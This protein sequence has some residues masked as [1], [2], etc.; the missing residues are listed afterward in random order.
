M[1]GSSSFHS[2]NSSGGKSR[3]TSAPPEIS[4]N[5]FDRWMPM[6]TRPTVTMPRYSPRSR[7]AEGETMMPDER[8]ADAGARQPDPDRQAEAPQVRRALAAEH[9]RRVGADAHEEGV[10]RATPGRRR[11]ESRLSPSAAMAKITAWVSSRIQSGSPRKRTNGSW[12]MTGSE[13]GSSTATTSNRARRDAL[14]PGR[15]DRRSRPG[16]WCGGAAGR[17]SHTLLIS[18]VP[19]SP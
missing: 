3:P 1:I 12:L 18:G 10:A 19:N 4:G 15:E 6:N 9:D 2:L 17:A 13:N 8:R 11:P 14:G 16:S 7:T 5:T